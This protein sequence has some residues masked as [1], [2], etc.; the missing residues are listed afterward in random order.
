MIM[1]FSQRGFRRDRRIVRLGSAG[2]GMVV[3][4]RVAFGGAQGLRWESSGR[5]F[6]KSL[7]L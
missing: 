1:D 4:R 7:L 2:V 6:C 5:L 3:A